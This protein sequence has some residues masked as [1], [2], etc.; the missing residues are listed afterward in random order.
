MKDSTKHIVLNVKGLTVGYENKQQQNRVAQDINFELKSGE[1]VALIGANGIGKSTLI[2]TLTKNQ[3]AL[4]GSIEVNTTNLSELNIHDLAKV[5]SVVFSKNQTSHN[6]TVQETIA[7][8]RYPYT[9]WLGSLTSEDLQQI[10]RAIDLLNLNDLKDKKCHEL[11]DGQLQKVM[12]ARALA[13]DTDIIILDEPTTH[14]DIYHKAYIL[15]LLKQLAERTNKTILFSTHEI[16]TALR[17]SDKLI[18]MHD[19]GT[20]FGSPKE[21]ANAQVFDK[22][23]PDD[24]VQFDSISNGFKIV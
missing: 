24:L 15:K 10:Q 22:L 5:L 6:Y 2:R 17:L 3:P 18:V 21:L 19:K 14:L 4:D 7:L 13:Q 16:N 8:A 23:F 11:S 20:D 12:I 1:L 9:N